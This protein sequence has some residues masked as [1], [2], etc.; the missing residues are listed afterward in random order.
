MNEILQ[1][2]YGGFHG[3]MQQCE[4]MNVNTRFMYYYLAGII[5]WDLVRN[6]CH[7]IKS[8]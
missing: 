4:Q 6:Q 2:Q 8:T 1:Q 3:F 5:P 7:N